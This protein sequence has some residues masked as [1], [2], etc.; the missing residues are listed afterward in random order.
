MKKINKKTPT[1]NKV[2]IDN[3][4]RTLAQS[5][6]LME[7]ES[8]YVIS[9]YKSSADTTLN[10]TKCIYMEAPLFGI[11]RKIFKNLFI[12]YA[13]DSRDFEDIKSDLTLSIYPTY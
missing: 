13:A 2:F 6:E 1:L 4:E 10:Y 12:N 5:I 8:V 11:D 9:S 3:V 7:D